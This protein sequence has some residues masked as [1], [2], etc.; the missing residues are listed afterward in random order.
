MLCHRKNVAISVADY[1]ADYV[2]DHVAN[3]V[4]DYVA[5]YVAEFVA[6]CVVEHMPWNGVIND[7]AV[8]HAGRT[9]SKH[10]CD[11]ARQTHCL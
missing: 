11:R 3:Y 8:V 7:V 5:D 9:R 1:V 6:E 4:A 2:A 10:A